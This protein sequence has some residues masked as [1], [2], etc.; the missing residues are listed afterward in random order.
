MFAPERVV[1]FT[2]GVFA[3]AITLLALPLTDARLTDSGLRDQLLALRHQLLSFVLSFLI[4]GR[5]WIA[6]HWMFRYIAR[7]DGRLLALNLFFILCIAFL[8]FPTKVVGE[9]G[10]TTTAAV[11]Y[12]ASMIAPYLL[13]AV[14]WYHASAGNQLLRVHVDWQLI[15]QWRRRLLVVP[16]LFVPSI[17][18]ALASAR[19]ASV[20]WWLA[21]PL[22]WLVRW[23]S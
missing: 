13:L 15:R 6:H 3:I 4:I 16:V 23:K 8:P 5:L 1:A 9:H 18:V 17:L 2:D 11:F 22:S 20:L 10:N 19:A 7:I 12:A 21:L 14:I